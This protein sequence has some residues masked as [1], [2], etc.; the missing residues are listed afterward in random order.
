[1]NRDRMIAELKL[2]RDRE[3]AAHWRGKRA[4]EHA[5]TYMEPKPTQFDTEIAEIKGF[6][7]NEMQ[8]FKWAVRMSHLLTNMLTHIQKLE[9]ANRLLDGDD[10]DNS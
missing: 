9:K 2:L 1:M 3:L 7:E 5:I 6:I 10:A 4:L 8:P